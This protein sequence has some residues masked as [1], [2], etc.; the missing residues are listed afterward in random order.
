MVF[1]LSRQKQNVDVDSVNHDVVVL[2]IESFIHQNVLCGYLF[3]ENRCNQLIR[4]LKL[5]CTNVE[6]VQQLFIYWN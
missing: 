2:V 6:M 4:Y 1:R 5:Y 3:P